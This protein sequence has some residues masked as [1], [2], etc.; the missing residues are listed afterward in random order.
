MASNPDNRIPVYLITGFLGAGKTTLVNRLLSGG[1]GEGAGLLVND[2]GDIVVDGSLIRASSGEPEIFEVA[3]GSI[4]C[5]CK[6]AN[7]ALGLRMFA[8]MR[9]VRLF[10]E[11]SGMSDPSGLDK[12]LSDY[13]L[14]ADFVLAKVLCL[15]DAVR[16]PMMMDNLPALSRQIEAA[17][18]ILLNK[19][20]LIDPPA[21][22][23]IEKKIR[24]INAEAEIIPT[25]RADIDADRLTGSSS[26]HRRGDIV[27]CDT[28]GSRPGTL[29]LE[30]D[31]I[32]KESVDAFLH[33]ML[34]AT[35]RIKG[36]IN[37]GGGWW[38][39]SDNAGSL[40]WIEDNLPMGMPPGL[41]VITPPGGDQAVADAWRGFVGQ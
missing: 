33:D 39:V 26:S 27:S 14:A 8:K 28:P 9:P 36:W 6:T 3:G 10:V 38:Y 11:A 17:D 7:F 23:D 29:Q 16:T 34:D 13:R 4:F 41:T 12:L 35:W 40:E 24:S 32:P 22:S 15:F 20:D 1:L 5:S 25:V 18:L 31:G 19:S 21:I 2:F 30:F 37:T